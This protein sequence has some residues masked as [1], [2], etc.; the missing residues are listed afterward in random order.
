MKHLRSIRTQQGL[1]LRTLAEQSGVHY[2]SLARMEAGTLDPRLSSVQRVA[3]ALKV[4]VSE[5]I[6]EQPLTKG[7]KAHGTD[8]TKG[9]V[10]RGVSRRG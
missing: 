3:K 7:R 5:L 8:Q 9:R 10:V 6:G 2:V 4:S 1:S